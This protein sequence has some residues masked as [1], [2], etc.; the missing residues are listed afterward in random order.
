MFW[1]RNMQE[2]TGVVDRYEIRHKYSIWTKCFDQCLLKHFLGY[3]NKHFEVVHGL[4][5]QLFQ[6][7]INKRAYRRSIRL[8]STYVSWQKLR[9]HAVTICVN[10]HKT[11]LLDG[12]LSCWS[13]VA[14]KTLSTKVIKFIH[15]LQISLRT[16]CFFMW[17]ESSYQQ[18]KR[19]KVPSMASL[20]IVVKICE[21]ATHTTNVCWTV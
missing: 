13:F 10:K 5:R 18:K 6:W 2:I 4:S 9:I 7:H 12:M 16:R 19:G 17:R 21:V 1:F 15:S 11:T 14:D 8:W 20:I 3:W